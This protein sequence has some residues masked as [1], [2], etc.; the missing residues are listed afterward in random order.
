VQ[1]EQPS[2][3]ILILPSKKIPEVLKH[4]IEDEKDIEYRFITGNRNIIQ[5]NKA[6]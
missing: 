6:N 3:I 5:K 1:N 2:N 4:L